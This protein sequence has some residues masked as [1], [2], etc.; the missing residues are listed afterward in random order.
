MDPATQVAI[1]AA[2]EELG[3]ARAALSK[4]SNT[5][6]LL[7]GVAALAA[8]GATAGIL[9][10]LTIAPGK[11][12]DEVETVNTSLARDE[13]IM[14]LVVAL[15]ADVRALNHAQKVLSSAPAKDKTGIEMADLSAKIDAISRRQQRLEDAIQSSPDKSLAIPLMRRDIDNVRDSSAQ[16]IASVKASVDQVYDLTKWLLGALAVGVFSLA[17]ANFFQRKSQ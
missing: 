4:G 6:K 10:S 5:S 9:A 16:S 14:R 15:Q 13:K 2:K 1:E 3:K 12:L 11:L 8:A 7:S 17:I